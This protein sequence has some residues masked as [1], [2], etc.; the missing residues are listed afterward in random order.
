MAD[1][2]SKPATKLQASML[3]DVNNGR[4]SAG[5]SFDIGD[6]PVIVRN[7]NRMIPCFPSRNRYSQTYQ[8]VP[9]TFI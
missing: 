2:P 8:N 6:P 3:R 7:R 4:F 5:A 9:A 1:A